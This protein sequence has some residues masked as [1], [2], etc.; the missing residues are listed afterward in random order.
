[1][2]KQFTLNLSAE[3]V[4]TIFGMLVQTPMPYATSAPLI[5]TI[6]AQVTAQNNPALPVIDPA[7]VPVEG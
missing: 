5:A 1:M 4:D 3:Q 2:S 6:Q 7:A